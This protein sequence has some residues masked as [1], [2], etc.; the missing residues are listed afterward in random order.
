M[1][2]NAAQN[3][4]QDLAQDT[5]Q[6]FDFGG[7]SPRY[8]PQLPPLSLRSWRCAEM[9]R[10]WAAQLRLARTLGRCFQGCRAK[11]L[12][13]YKRVYSRAPAI[14][15][16]AQPAALICPCRTRRAELEAIPPPMP[17]FRA[18]LDVSIHSPSWHTSKEGARNPKQG[19]AARGVM[20]SSS[21]GATSSWVAAPSSLACSRLPPASRVRVATT[22]ILTSR[23][24]TSSTPSSQT[25][26]TVLTPV[27]C[28]QTGVLTSGV[29]FL[30][31][32]WGFT[33]WLCYKMTPTGEGKKNRS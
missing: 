22:P 16:H 26:D 28:E 5:E 7:S 13:V 20:R 14:H 24:T 10:N 21:P 1:P 33:W 15:P 31:F 4:L 17:R 3:V 29:S 12:Y 9:G 32:V 18:M 8:T 23:T 6:D 11:R 30:V 2:Q 25:P 19:P 27:R